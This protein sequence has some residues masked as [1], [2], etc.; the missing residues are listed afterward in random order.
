MKR[1]VVEIQELQKVV[2][3]HQEAVVVQQRGDVVDQ[4]IA[5]AAQIVV[6]AP[7]WTEF[8]R[9]EAG[10]EFCFAA[11]KENPLQSI[12]AASDPQRQLKWCGKNYR[13]VEDV[14]D[15]EH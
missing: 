11:R 9:P 10:I 13:K 15:V 7:K 12:A 4:I 2:A 14:S 8:E 5:A 3:S 6:V 1:M